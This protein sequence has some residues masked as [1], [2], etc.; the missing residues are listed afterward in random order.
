MS[1]QIQISLIFMVILDLE[2]MM[3]KDGYVKIQIHIALY[4]KIDAHVISF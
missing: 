2:C 3:Q 1:L 4:K